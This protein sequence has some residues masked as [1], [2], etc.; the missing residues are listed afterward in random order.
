MSYP[1]KVKA[2]LAGNTT[3]VRM[4]LNHPMESGRRKDPATGQL[5]PAHYI[6]RITVSVNGKEMLVA[7]T[8]TSVAKDPAFSF[9]LKG[10][11]AG[12]KV[13]V[14]WKDSKGESNSAEAIV[15]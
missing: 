2:T 1:M 13:T 12:D 6:Q 14:A 10:G 11:K 3:D 8:S 4:I 15:G 5:V 7:H 9:L